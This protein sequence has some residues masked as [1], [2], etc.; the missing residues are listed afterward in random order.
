MQ[1]AL[2]V[3]SHFV[4]SAGIKVVAT[5]KTCRRFFVDFETSFV[6][7]DFADTNRGRVHKIH[8]TYFNA[9][10]NNSQTMTKEVTEATY[11]AIKAACQK[12]YRDG[13]AKSTDFGKSWSVNTA[14][15][16]EVLAQ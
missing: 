2:R 11:K 13:L 10:E 1:A 14:K 3:A 5:P 15:L 9:A 16:T 12:L 8:W 7:F 6:R 4:G